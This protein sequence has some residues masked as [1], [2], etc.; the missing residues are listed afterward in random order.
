M[1]WVEKRPP[2]RTSGPNSIET[3]A[4][5]AEAIVKAE[6]TRTRRANRGHPDQARQPLAPIPH[7]RTYALGLREDPR[8]TRQRGRGA[9]LTINRQCLHFFRKQP[10]RSAALV[11][12]FVAYMSAYRVLSPNP[13]SVRAAIS[14]AVKR[15][16]WV[17]AGPHR[18]SRISWIS[19]S[20]KRSS[21]CRWPA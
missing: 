21:P 18:C 15:R 4:E 5:K 17:V 16:S 10:D 2:V 14:S 6:R 1:T 12:K 8:L 3:F 13:W 19:R 11:L 20:W 9:A 7:R